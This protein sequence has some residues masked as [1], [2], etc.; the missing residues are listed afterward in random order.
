MSGNGCYA[1]YRVDM[2]NDQAST[3]LL[4]DVLGTLAARFNTDAAHIDATVYNAAR[5][6]GLVGTLKVK[7][8][9][10][11]ERPHRRSHV[12]S[13]P[14]TIRA[15]ILE[16]LRNL[17]PPQVSPSVPVMT[18]G[19]TG[20]G[21]PALRDMLDAAGIE[22]REQPPDANG[23]TWY[24][25]PRCPFHEDGRDFECGVGQKLPDGPY[26]GHGF[27]PEC[28]DKGWQEWKLA[29]GLQ[30][31][32]RTTALSRPSAEQPRKPT[33]FARTDTGNAE[34]F[35]H[36]FG[37][38][39]RYDH[40]RRRWLVWA[41]Q[42]WEV[43]ADGA[44]TRLAIDAVRQ[45][46]L[47]A[48][49]LPDLD[50]RKLQARFA[51]ASEN[52]QRLEAMLSVARNEPPIS[53]RGDSWDRD[54]LLLGVVN[55]AVD[56][57]TGVLLPG[58]PGQGITKFTPL[59]F[60]P[61]ASCPR[62]LQFLNEIFSGDEELIDFIWRAAGYS[63]TGDTSEQCVFACF[64]T[65]SNGKSVLLSIMRKLAGTYAYNAPFS[66]FEL[67][68]RGNI[69]NDVAA[70]AGARLVTSSET[71]EGTRLN[72]AR[73]KALTG[74]DPITARFLNREFFTFYAEAK[75]WLAVNH[76]PRVE[77]E[78][79][80]FWRRV[81]LIPFNRT[82][83]K[84]QDKGL[85]AKLV[86]ELPGILAWAV[87]GCLEWQRRGLEPPTVV[88]AATEAYRVESD[89]L[90]PFLEERCVT[91]DDYVVGATAVLRDYQAWASRNG[92]RRQEILTSPTFG[93][94]MAARF[95]RQHTKAGNVYRGVGLLSEQ[96]A[97]PSLVAPVKGSV[98]GFES[99][100]QKSRSE[101]TENNVTREDQETAF[102]TLHP[103]PQDESACIQCGAGVSSYTP[104]GQPLCAAHAEP[105][106]VRP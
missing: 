102:T 53:E 76:R 42:H 104:D 18:S 47:E 46:Y 98:K 35:A 31:G 74:N 29:L 106:E 65:G 20:T 36:L 8:D 54:P 40:L 90:A 89:P 66:V 82:F 81:R 86:R 6:I 94:K 9:E 27:H 79:F 7:G 1:L 38:R 61:S 45:R 87:A 43:D 64:G 34:L 51:V 10:T 50:D 95:E 58:E 73:L 22:Y 103:S 4:K 59:R 62:W 44:V 52:R 2:P 41:G 17:V 69:P 78:S 71:N 67:Q 97:A 99:M 105:T 14:E 96:A 30:V 26:A 72:E 48:M 63:L 100:N 3:A 60:D 92:L 101:L 83:D 16:Q 80:G 70:L 56:L 93:K 85:E 15:V 84:D 28:V 68:N 88:T 33:D 19:P 57:R 32:R 75:F 91:G 5:I 11:P 21:A 55:G 13:A 37:D 23:V 39:L 24:H 77:D 49:L 25:V 12:L